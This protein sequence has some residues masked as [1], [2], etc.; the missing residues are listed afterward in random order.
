M[1]G[2]DI[3]LF[4]FIIFVSINVWLF[5]SMKRMRKESLKSSL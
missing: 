2:W 3:A 4:G 5:F 1:K